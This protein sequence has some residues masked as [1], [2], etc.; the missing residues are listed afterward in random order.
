MA[1]CKIAHY[2]IDV[3]DMPLCKFA[4]DHSKARAMVMGKNKISNVLQMK[5]IIIKAK[6]AN[7]IGVLLILPI[8]L[9]LI[10]PYLLQWKD[11]AIVS[12]KEI[13]LALSVTGNNLVDTLITVFTPVVIIAIGVV[14][15]EMI[16][17]LFM[18]IFS[19]NRK[20][21]K[22]GFRR[23]PFMPYA[24]CSKALISRQM[25]IV[26]LAPWIILGLVPFVISLVNG[27][28]VLLLFG[29]SMTYAA[30]GDFIYTILI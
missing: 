25:I 29:A 19:G 23:D 30:V 20:A 21:V 10:I 5:E 3:L 24:H 13:G 11:E 9:V 2:H 17:G 7:R 26:C 1:I 12:I 18:L 15:H 22:F 8:S 27:N 14:L 4:Y 28:L 6:E 16:H